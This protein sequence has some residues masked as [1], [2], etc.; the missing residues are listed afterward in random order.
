MKVHVFGNTTSPAIATYALRKTVEGSDQDVKDFVTKNFY[1]DDGL[2][3]TE[4][5]QKSVDLMK[6]TQRDLDER[7]NL[8]LHK[9]ASNS[10]ELMNHFPNI[11]LSKEI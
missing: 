6:K 10:L 2:I 5:V 11:D 4:T 3:S 9:I 1:V 8:K 7:G